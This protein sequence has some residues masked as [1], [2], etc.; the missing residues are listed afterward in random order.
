MEIIWLVGRILFSALFI[1]SGFGHFRNRKEM[2][3]YAQMMKAPAPELFV[4]LTGIMIILGGLSV[5]FNFYLTVGAILLFLFLVPVAFIMHKFWGVQDPGLSANQ[6]AHFFKNLSLA[7][8]SLILI[9]LDYI[10]KQ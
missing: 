1:M 5:L 2:I 10:S 8:A 7:G 6:M 3:Q 9:Y 4:P